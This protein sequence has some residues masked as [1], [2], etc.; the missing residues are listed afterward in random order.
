M[1]CE[2][3]EKWT[4]KVRGHGWHR[5]NGPIAGGDTLVVVAIDRI[6]SGQ[7]RPIRSI[8]DLRDRG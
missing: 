1:T 4:L 5:L 3:L 6:V 8:C 7:H 2:K